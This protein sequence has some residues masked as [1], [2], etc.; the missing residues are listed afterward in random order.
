M[1]RGYRKGRN[2]TGNIGATKL[3]SWQQ[4]IRQTMGTN[5]TTNTEG[6]GLKGERAFTEIGEDE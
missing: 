5:R 1:N 2:K 6:E 4:I 3:D